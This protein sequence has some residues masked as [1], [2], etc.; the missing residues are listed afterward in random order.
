[1]LWSFNSEIAEPSAWHDHGMFQLVLCRGDNGRM[2]TQG[3][4]VTF[5]P[6]RTLL[7]PPGTLHRFVVGPGE[8]GRLKIVC[9]PPKDLPQFL[10]PLHITML[11]GLVRSGVSIADHDGQERWLHHLGDAILDGFG[12]DD[13]WGQRMQWGI[14]GLLL[15][16][17]AKEQH[18]TTGHPY[19]RHK[20]KIMA[21]L[22]WIESNLTEEITLEQV[23]NRFGISRSLLTR[24]FRGHTGKSLV[25]Y[26][27]ARRV[28]KAA[29]ALATTEH[30]V[31]RVALESGFSNLSH[32]HRQFKSQ[33]GITPAAF[34]RKIEEEG[35]L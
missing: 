5:A 15:T 16:L 33:F 6:A 22:S 27:N 32:F 29:I 14:V 3:Q 35:S 19:L 10:S 21:I 20:T 28:Q 11:D 2:L 17:H 23:S 1:M 34:R 26:C 9:F 13:V 8:I 30:P 18:V 4:E 7:I 25:D 31:I 24:E 12:N